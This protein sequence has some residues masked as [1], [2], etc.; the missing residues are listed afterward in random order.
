M[1]MKS[2]THDNNGGK[3]ESCFDCTN[4]TFIIHADVNFYM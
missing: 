1:W 2:I 3:D 4:M